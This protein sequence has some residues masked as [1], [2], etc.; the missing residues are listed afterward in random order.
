MITDMNKKAYFGNFG[1]QF[2]P[3]TLIPLL[4]E[5]DAGFQGAMNDQDF[6]T[7]W[8]SMLQTY[9]GR[10]SPLMFAE[11]L[12]SYIGGGKIFLKRDE[13][14][15]T[16]SHKMNNC[17]GQALLA[18]HLGK[19]HIIAETGAGQHGVATATMAAHL[20]MKCS[21]FMGTKDMQRQK[22]NVQKMRILGANIHPVEQGS[23]TLKDAMS[24]AIRF[25]I[26]N[27]QGT[28]YII[29]S[30]AGPHPY[31]KM[32]RFFQSI[33]GAEA[34]EQFYSLQKGLPDAVIACIGGGS[35]AIGLFSAFLDMSQVK[36]F[37]VEAGGD[38]H[39]SGTASTLSKGSPGILHGTFSYVLQDQH[40]Q[41]I[42]AQSL[43]PGLDYPGVGPEHAYLKETQRVTYVSV[44]DQEAIHAFSICA[45]QE[46]IFPALEPSHALAFAMKYAK[47]NPHKALIVNLCGRGDKDLDTFLHY[48][49]ESLQ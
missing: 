43:A 42:D 3:E 25:W 27:H 21:I 10:P 44:H 47:K 48:Q 4:Q 49:K 13:L 1:G 16:G 8:R 34:K 39:G 32:V 40:G 30:V 41:I 37:G 31:P 33:I 14:N 46:G 23:A 29:G 7:R 20:G 35:N 15:H 45:R 24:A 5:V 28:F 19:R 18:E 38:Q 22:M 11:R 12:S 9:V 6:L 2:V 17:L 26:A 36:M